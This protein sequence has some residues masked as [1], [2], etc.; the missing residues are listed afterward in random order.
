VLDGHLDG[1][2]PGADK[3]KLLIEQAGRLLA[4]SPSHGDVAALLAG[5]EALAPRE[6]V[7]FDGQSR[8]W[9]SGLSSEAIARLRWPFLRGGRKRLWGVLG[10]VSADGRERERAVT[11]GELSPLTTRLLAVRSVDWVTEVR[12]AAL[13]RLRECP[14]PLL[15]EALA[16]ADQIAVERL[17]GEELDALL[18][19][20]L[21]ADDLRAATRVADRRTRRAAWRRLVARGL[22]RFEELRDVAAADEDVIVRSVAASALSDLSAQQQRTLARVLVYDSI[23]SVATTA[24]AALVRLDGAAAIEQA[25]TGPSAAARRAARDWAAVRGVDA[26]AVY[27]TRLGEQPRDR[28]ALTALAEIG[29]AQDA[30]LF[31][32]LLADERPRIRAA[33]LR[34]LA[35][36]DQATA[37][38][39]AVDALRTGASGR[40][41][42]AATD[43]LR[44][45]SLG[46]AE[47]EAVVT[48]A[49]DRSRPS[50]HRFRT[51]RNRWHHLAVVLEARA[52][53]GDG[54][55]RALLDHA[56]LAWIAASRRI[57]R[58][59]DP[60]IR[61]RVE[62]LLDTLGAERRREIDFVLRTTRPP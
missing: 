17:R 29:D 47:L 4:G 59:P 62:R 30:D 23:G 36:V 5:L 35:R 38:A 19:A 52:A 26:R 11:A 12:A 27:L 1:T 42:T 15:T 43:V 60:A 45:G 58:G 9:L 51:R 57:G 53:E 24:L 50:S 54:D 56:V 20:R 31:R 25:L 46:G 33:G 14:A 39:A 37:R 22:P 44:E 40:V 48:I 21:S 49:L 7:R 10:L 55:V 2:G 41:V 18:D 13:A 32:E 3:V 8:S 28:I 34:A 61:G 6:L 16:L